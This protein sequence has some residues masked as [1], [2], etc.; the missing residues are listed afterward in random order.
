VSIEYNQND[1]NKGDKTM[2]IAVSA[3]A[4]NGL[5]SPVSAH[6]GH[7]PCFI[8]ADVEDGEVKNVSSVDNPY[9]GNHQP[10]QMPAFLH[11]QGVDVMLSGGMGR[12]AI[13]FFE[14]YGIEA[15]TGAS[16]SVG[17]TLQ[18]YL[19]GQLTGSQPCADSEHHHHH[20]HGHGGR[21]EH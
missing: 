2:R 7:A 1:F 6:F 21:G 16:G 18:R 5:D 9:H 14:Q 11:Q 12:R 10:G 15:V 17:Q 4:N 8:L 13:M 19:D 3:E 20:G